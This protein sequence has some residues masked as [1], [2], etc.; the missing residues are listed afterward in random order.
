MKKGEVFR[1]ASNIAIWFLVAV[2]IYS[3]INKWGSDYWDK[4][5]WQ[6][7]AAI[8]TWI[9]AIGVIYAFLQLHQA[10]KNTN[11]QLAVEL[12]KA[13]REDE[14]MDTLRRVYRLGPKYSISSLNN[15]DEFE[16]KCKK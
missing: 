7:I 2:L 8:G 10:K 14:A 5:T 15:D 6:V 16:K 3:I 1:L 11:A 13:L 4:D 9:L 12:F